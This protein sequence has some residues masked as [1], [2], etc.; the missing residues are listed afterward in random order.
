MSA[1]DRTY[2]HG[3]AEEHPTHFTE[4]VIARLLAPVDI[5]SIIFFRVCFGLI[6]FW[7]V[8]SQIPGVTREYIAPDFHFS[9]YGLEFLQP[10][11]G[12]WM[13]AVFF[14]MSAAAV[15]IALGCYY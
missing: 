8:W 4:R 9:H 6:S 7:H 1:S 11:P 2:C 15:G 3:M 12:E 14:V 10:L 5:A 13:H